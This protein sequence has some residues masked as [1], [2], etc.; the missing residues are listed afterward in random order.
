VSLHDILMVA[1]L[2][3]GATIVALR[4]IH[5]W[6]TGGRR[7]LDD[8][9][10]QQKIDERDASVAYWRGQLD[11]DNPNLA[12]LARDMLV[13]YGVDELTAEQQ[14]VAERADEHRRQRE[15]EHAAALRRAADIAR[16]DPPIA[17]VLTQFDQLSAYMIAWP[18]DAGAHRRREH[19]ALKILVDAYENARWSAGADRE[20]AGHFEVDAVAVRTWGG[21]VC[22]EYTT[23]NYRPDWPEPSLVD[24]EI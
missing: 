18:G 10:E 1:L 4:F 23:I 11:D 19:R 2:V 12:Q 6:W 8:I 16:R 7:T 5:S 14:R 15:R 17:E 3:L 21:S 24:H 20:L 13:F 22:A 9:I